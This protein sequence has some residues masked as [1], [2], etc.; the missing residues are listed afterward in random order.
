MLIYFAHPIDQADPMVATEAAQVA[1]L[2]H[3]VGLSVY[4]PGGAFTVADAPLSDL[5]TVDRI[6]VNAL[7]EADAVVAWLPPGV[8][9]LGVPAEI[10]A[11]LMLNKPTVIFSKL[12]L[13]SKSVQIANWRSR[14]ATVLLLDGST[15]QQMQANP[16]ALVDFL[17]QHP[18]P[19]EYPGTDEMIWTQVKGERSA[20]LNKGKYPGDAGIDLAI[21]EETTI[22]SRHY[23]LV[24]TGVSVAIPEGYFGWITGRSSTWANHRCDVRTAVIDSGYRGELMIGIDNRGHLPVVFPAGARLGQ[25]VLLPTWQG[26]LTYSDTLPESDRGT[27]GYGSSG[28]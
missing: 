27:N 24:P 9:T 12:P 5:E 11:A 3:D 23:A 20:T 2:L 1:S 28:A 15:A 7:W 8:A 6:N 4:R 25:L 14:G 18:R 19:D 22:A 17:R 10:E 13:I 26:D 16:V 21:S